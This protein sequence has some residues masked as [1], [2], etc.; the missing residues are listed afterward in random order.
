MW[1]DLGWVDREENRLMVKTAPLCC[2][3]SV[4]NRF[5]AGRL[6]TGYPPWFPSYTSYVPLRSLMTDV[7]WALSGNSFQILWDKR[8]VEVVLDERMD[9]SVGRGDIVGGGD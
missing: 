4:W 6:C 9:E 2:V 3:R 5:V 7:V 1:D 8:E